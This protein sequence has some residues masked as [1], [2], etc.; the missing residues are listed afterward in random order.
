MTGTNGNYLASRCVITNVHRLIRRQLRWF[1]YYS[2]LPKSGVN[3]AARIGG[4]CGQ[5]VLRACPAYRL[6]RHVEVPR[7][8]F[9]GRMAAMLWAL[10][11][12]SGTGI[13]LGLR[14]RASAVLAASVVLVALCIIVM[15][16][17]HWSLLP[18]VAFIFGLLATLQCGYLV[19]LMLAP[20]ILGLLSLA[21]SHHPTGPR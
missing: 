16:F 6:G 20:R 4:D 13:L 9:F 19:G 2:F 1:G 12:T 5:L 7:W 15:P 21:G 18:A 8:D 3:A 10:A 17:A 11:L 14:L